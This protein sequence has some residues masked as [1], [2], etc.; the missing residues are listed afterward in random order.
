MAESSLRF[1]SKTSRTTSLI[2]ELA[3]DLAMPS[4][5]ALN[6]TLNFESARWATFSSISALLAKMMA[7]TTFCV[8]SVDEVHA[9]LWSVFSCC[10]RAILRRIY[11]RRL[12][13]IVVWRFLI[14]FTPITRSVASI[15]SS[16]Q[17]TK[18]VLISER[19][20]DVDDLYSWTRRILN[21]RRFSIVCDPCQ[22]LEVK[23]RR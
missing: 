20:A 17:L 2:S 18:K 9:S 16:K 8:V 23:G 15:F 22:N 6:K 19:C 5:M 1:S 4:V 14:V 12:P 21:L 10:G 13:S 7:L 11:S 3:S